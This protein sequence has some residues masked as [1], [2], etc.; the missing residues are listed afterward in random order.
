MCNH[1]SQCVFILVTFS[2]SIPSES[3]IQIERCFSTCFYVH[4]QFAQINLSGHTE[5]SKKI[6]KENIAKKFRCVAE[7]LAY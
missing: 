5:N 4:F 6:T 7:K 3:Q 1:G 2:V